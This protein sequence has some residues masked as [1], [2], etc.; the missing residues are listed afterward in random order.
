MRKNIFLTGKSGCGKSTLLNK[1]LDSLNIKYSGYRTL[2]YYINDKFKGFYIHGYVDY[3]YNFSPISI[4]VGDRK[5]IGI[6]ETFQNTGYEIL[7]RSR[8]SEEN[9]LILMDEIGIFEEEAINFKREIIKS[10]ECEKN[11]LG[12]IKKKENTF[13]KEISERS[14]VLVIDI[15]DKTSLEVEEIKCKIIK[16][17]NK[18]D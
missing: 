9:N 6:K 8:T 1:I 17:L 13:L 5:S 12:V 10:L 7:K 14:D 18:I 2:P 15:E 4:K 3:E 11:V 16:I